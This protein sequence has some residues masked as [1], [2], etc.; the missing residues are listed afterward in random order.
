MESACVVERERKIGKAKYD[1]WGVTY[2]ARVRITVRFGSTETIREGC[3]AGHGIDRDCG[4]AHESAIK[5]AETDAMKRALM[6]LGNKFGLALYDK[7]Q[8]NVRPD[9]GRL[10]NAQARP[11]SEEINQLIRSAPS[12][13]D[14]DEIWETIEETRL[15]TLPKG[16]AERHKEIYDNKREELEAQS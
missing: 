7:T 12:V 10:T 2:T 4:Q 1:G 6:T 16:W 3:G 8:A 14:L 13:A 15:P 9:D 11:V 5:E